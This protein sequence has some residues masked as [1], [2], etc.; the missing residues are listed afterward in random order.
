[1]PLLSHP[2]DLMMLEAGKVTIASK[3][4]NELPIR[5]ICSEADVNSGMFNYYF[6]SKENFY[7]SLIESIYNELFAYVDAVFNLNDNAILQLKNC[8][9]RMIEF[10]AI[11][12]NLM[13]SIYYDILLLNKSLI[14]GISKIFTQKSMLIDLIENCRKEEYFTKNF[15]HWII[16]MITSL[17]NLP[18]LLKKNV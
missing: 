15:R 8:L 13:L 1:M 11:K 16:D 7:F 2:L 17:K 3:C 12:D 6:S 4:V 9:D 14:A 5:N 18:R 10:T